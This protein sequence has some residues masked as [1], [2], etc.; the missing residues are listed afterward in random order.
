MRVA[1]LTN[2]IAPYRVPLFEA[3]AQRCGELRVFVSTRMESNRQWQ[4]AWGSLDVV[5]QK[6]IT[7]MR[8]WRA[9]EFSEALEIHV[10]YD[11]IAQLRRY[12]PDV[13]LTGEMG[14]RTMQA[15]AYA[16][17]TGT[18]VVL[19][20]MLSEHTESS[21]G[22]LRNFIRRRLVRFVDAIIVNGESGARYFH[23]LGV[24]D[25]EI[26]RIHQWIDASAFRA[27]EHDGVGHPR[28]L[29]HVGSVSERKGVHLLFE[30]LQ[31]IKTPFHL[32]MVG[33]G[34]LRASLPTIDN[35]TWVGNVAYESLPQYYA[36]ADV[37]VFP[38][39]ADEWGLVVNE[40]LASGV[41]VL[42]SNYA[43]AVTELVTDGVNGWRFTPDSADD[44]RVALE[45]AL[46]VD[47]ATL[48]AMRA[49][50]TEEDAAGAIVNALRSVV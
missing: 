32:T 27:V 14:P 50:P 7:R 40:A 47:D 25:K 30:A 33:D 15:V 26:A 48:L 17:M 2:F 36:N 34:P 18:P 19:W 9:K 10:P 11:T 49:R 16:R 22:A 21:R 39:L 46:A 28:R 12:R 29:L 20:A 37:L 41:P 38:S 45:R 23:K 6:T 24:P 13:I 1:L 35:V 3:I 42:G 5:E 4:P 8:M 44:V 31:R 43:Q